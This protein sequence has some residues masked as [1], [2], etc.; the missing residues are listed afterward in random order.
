MH[1]HGVRFAKYHQQWDYITGSFNENSMLMF[2]KRNRIVIDENQ[3]ALD[4]I[5]HGYISWK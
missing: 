1:V 5:T 4:A 3:S 2:N